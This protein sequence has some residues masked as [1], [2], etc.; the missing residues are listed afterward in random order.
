MTAFIQYC[1]EQARAAD[2]IDYKSLSA[3]L[4]IKNMIDGGSEVKK[5]GETCEDEAQHYW[6]EWEDV[7][8]ALD[9]LTETVEEFRK[10]TGSE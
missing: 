6:K 3:F 7:E 5:V 9:G 8:K 1:I 2:D 10:A 4:K